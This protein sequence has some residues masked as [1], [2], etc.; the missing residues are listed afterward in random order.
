MVQAWYQGGVSVF[1]LTDP[2]HPKEIAYF[3]RG[4]LDPTSW[5]W[6]ATG[7]TYWYNGHIYGS[8][9]LRGLD[10]FELTPSG[11]LSQNEIDAAKSVQA[12]L[13]QHPGAG[14]FTWPKSYSLARA[15]LDQLERSKGMDR[16]RSPLPGPSWRRRRR[17]LAAPR[18][19]R[20]QG[21]CRSWN[22]RSPERRTPQRFSCWREPLSS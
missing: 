17:R 11:F 10:V 22:P 5:C 16:P 15:Y 19:R 1:D 4:P 12:G 9:I 21:W 8:E 2:E 14:K 18:V 6:A 7:R 13:F 3:D 20:W